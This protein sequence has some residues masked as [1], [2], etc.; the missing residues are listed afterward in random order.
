MM[1]SYLRYEPSHSFGVICSPAS[2]ITY[3]FS[4]NLL[5]TSAVEEVIVWNARQANKVCSLQASTSNYPYSLPG[6]VTCIERSNDKSSVASGYST[7]EI[8]IFNYLTRSV[9]ATLR[10]HRSGISC[11]SYDT[12]TTSS[13]LASGGKDSDIYI[14]DMVSYAGLF[15]LRGHKDVVTAVKFLAISTTQRYL[16]SVSKDTLLKVWDLATQHCVQTIVGHRSEIWTMGM[17]IYSHASATEPT[18]LIITGASDSLLRGYVVKGS[19]IAE[20]D[21]PQAQNGE[22]NEILEYIGSLEREF[23]FDKCTGV[24]FNAAGTVLVAQS[25]GKNI[26]V[27]IRP[28]SYHATY[29]IN[30]IE[31]RYIQCAMLAYQIKR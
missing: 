24:S 6:E 31:F 17:H 25:S 22:E 2:N 21:V 3:D 8:R 20:G 5:L 14:W 16:I 10:G 19:S 13:L 11:L 12:D 28:Q 1:K 7:G 30:C 4:G 23:G 18:H 27:M 9:L 15:K 26:E 29:E